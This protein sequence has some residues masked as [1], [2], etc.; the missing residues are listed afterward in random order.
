MV[1]T[2]RSRATR[3][4]GDV[5]QQYLNVGRGGLAISRPFTTVHF[6]VHR[7]IH[8]DL[9]LA[10]E[11]RGA[12]DVSRRAVAYGIVDGDEGIGTPGDIGT[13]ARTLKVWLRISQLKTDPAF[14]THLA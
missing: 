11:R 8:S 5:T 10:D 14:T 1:E 13:R 9:T 4:R 7:A 3:R 12:E 6:S 2:S